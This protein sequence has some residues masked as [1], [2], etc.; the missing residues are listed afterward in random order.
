MSTFTFNTNTIRVIEIDGQPWFVVSD[1]CKTLMLTNASVSVQLLDADELSKRNLGLRGM[2][3]AIIVSEP[4]LYK[5]IGRSHKP[6]AKKFD[7][8]VRHEVLPA[9]RKDGMYVLGE[10][11]VKTG[12][13]SEDELI[14]G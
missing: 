2:G 7:R 6:E 3:S 10:E 9:I 12:E 8:W 5:L 4:G 13:M 1:V 14:Y 11:K